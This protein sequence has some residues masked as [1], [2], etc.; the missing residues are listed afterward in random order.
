MW[1]V[2]NLRSY[3]TVIAFTFAATAIGM[4]SLTA[5]YGIS[6]E[7]SPPTIAETRPALA[8]SEAW[9]EPTM[10]VPLLNNFQREMANRQN[11]VFANGLAASIYVGECEI[12]YFNAQNIP[13]PEGLLGRLGI[14]ALL[15]GN[16]SSQPPTKLSAVTDAITGYCENGRYDKTMFPHARAH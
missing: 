7:P 14:V 15:R 6:Q 2:A 16:G 1:I 5:T 12:L 3:L 4:A 8:T 9:K 11:D 13:G 10:R